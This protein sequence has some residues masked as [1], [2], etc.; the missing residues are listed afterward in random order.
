MNR[1]QRAK[2]KALRELQNK[3]KHKRNTV[4]QD[5]IS[6]ICDTKYWT[7]VEREIRKQLCRNSKKEVTTS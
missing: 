5:G 6:E 7:C 3:A 4:I 1:T 2:K